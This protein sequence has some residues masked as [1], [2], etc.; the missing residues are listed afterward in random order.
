MKRVLIISYYWPPTGGSGVQRWVKF[1]K[2]LPS[3]GW[4]PVVYTPENP[5][6]LAV[7]HSLEAEI[8]AE[9]EVLKTH[10]TEPYELYRR[11]GRL[12]SP[13]SHHEGPSSSCHP[14]RRSYPC[15]L[16]RP[17]SLCHPERPQGV[18]G[19]SPTGLACNGAQK[20]VNPI[21]SQK[22]SLGQ[23]LSMWIRGNLFIPDPRCMWIGPSVKYLK[24]YLAEHP[25]DVIVSTGPPQ[26]MHLIARKL[27]LA[28]GIP[29]IADFRDPWTRM[30]YFKHLSLSKFSEWRHGRLEKKV[31]DD[32]TVVVAVSPL[33]Q[34]DFQAMTDTPVELI[35]NGYD[36]SDFADITSAVA[37][38]QFD[39]AGQFDTAGQSGATG[40]GVARENIGTAQTFTVVHTGLFANDGNPEILWH[41]LAEK[42]AAEPGFA[43]ALRIRLAGK[44]DVE[45]IDSIVAAGL[46]DKLTDLGYK[47][48]K[49]V[50][51][52]QQ[53]ADLLMLPLRKEPEY[54]ATLPGKLFEY[55]ASQKPILGI[56]Q[57]DG[58]MAQILAT[59]SSGV[60]FDWNDAASVRRYIDLCYENKLR[61]LPTISPH[62]LEQYSRR[63]LTRRLAL[64]MNSLVK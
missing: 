57:T 11:L 36:E 51:T 41:A 42:C 52:L 29:W 3:E 26:S 31:L 43:S 37:P 50:V 10:I 4:Q 32:A 17:S 14:E 47:A 53:S 55:L 61:G 58:A 5:E 20:E 23:K 25:V 45:I 28:T 35:T 46:G 64:L 63:G 49:E 7:D 59:T 6:M 13:F 40:E 33:V 56:G 2:Y 1:A 54:K 12:L 30:F 21:N 62:D 39:A 48:H 27:H 16:E 24:K 9:V 22:K 44:T 60:V 8:P 19:S 38:E 34:Q 15:P 18:E